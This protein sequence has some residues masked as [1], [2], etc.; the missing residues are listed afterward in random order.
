MTEISDD[1]QTREQQVLAEQ[2]E[3]LAQRNGF[4]ERSEQVLR[5][6]LEHLAMQTQELKNELTHTDAELMEV[7]SKLKDAL[8]AIAKLTSLEFDI[9][10]LTIIHEKD[11]IG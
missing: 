8:K 5:E 4:A 7:R 9:F 11:T 2:R 3:I 1:I 10:S 6:R